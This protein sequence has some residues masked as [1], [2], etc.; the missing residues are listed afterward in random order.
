MVLG[1]RE[2]VQS[3]TTARAAR[4]IG[5]TDSALLTGLF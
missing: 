5:L 4:Q 3:G 1:L 2:S